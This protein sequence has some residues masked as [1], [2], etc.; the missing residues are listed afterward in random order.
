L[1]TLKIVGE[2]PP[3]DA[4]EVEVRLP[5]ALFEG[6]LGGLAKEIKV[7][8]RVLLDIVEAVSGERPPIKVRTLSD[9]SVEIFL[10]V[11]P[12]SGVAILTLVTAIVNLIN[13]VMQTRKT[14]T[15]LEKAQAPQEVLDGLIKWEQNRVTSELDQLRDKLLKE[16][17]ADKGRKNEL[18]KAL[19]DSL[20]QLANRID[21]G[22]DIE[23][24]TLLG[25]A[26]TSVENSTS[27]MNSI[28]A[29]Q[30]QIVEAM[31][32]RKLRSRSDQPILSLPSL[33]DEEEPDK[34]K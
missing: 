5:F 1:D 31:R 16:S 34:L 9:G 33:A 24:A 28:A 14:R 17:T 6:S 12:L 22:M 18:K 10:T 8:D 3:T 23:V 25:E 20:K 11:D 27:D 13:S 21:R 32:T 30:Q 26:T 15:E 29:A 4:A 19:S 2:K 7:L